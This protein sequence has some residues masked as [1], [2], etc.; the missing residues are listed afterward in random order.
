MEGSVG[1]WDFHGVGVEDAK[2]GICPQNVGGGVLVVPYM[3]CL[4]FVPLE[5][6]SRLV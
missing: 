3:Y 4:I 1:H 5:F 6:P 2:V